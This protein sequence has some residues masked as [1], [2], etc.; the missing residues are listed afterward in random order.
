MTE[1]IEALDKNKWIRE[2]KGAWGSMTLLAPKP[3]QEGVINVND[4]VWRLCVSYRG[5]NRVTKSF[6]FPNSRCADSI[7][8]FGDSN[9]IIFLLR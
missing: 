4:F 9:G 6:M 7:K 2:C 8:D 5:L 3:N 1:Y